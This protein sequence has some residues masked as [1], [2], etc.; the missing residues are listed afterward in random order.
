[1]GRQEKDHYT[2]YIPG[3]NDKQFDLKNHK[4]EA[5]SHHQ[6]IPV[7]NLKSSLGHQPLAKTKEDVMC[8]SLNSAKINK[9]RQIAGEIPFYNIVDSKLN[10]MSKTSH[11]IPNFSQDVRSS[12]R[13]PIKEKP[14]NSNYSLNSKNI[15]NFYS[16]LKENKKGNNFAKIDSSVGRENTKHSIY[17]INEGYNL[18]Q[19]HKTA[20]DQWNVKSMMEMSTSTDKI[21]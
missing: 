13:L 10:T 6:K 12:D 1:M 11:S 17:S 3:A 15:E 2:D 5:V 21:V 20:F 8:A 16:N 18:D 19:G 9:K 7:H 4:W 14:Y